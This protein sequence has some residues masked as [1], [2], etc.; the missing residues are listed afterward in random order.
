[1]QQQQTTTTVVSHRTIRSGA[2]FKPD[3][4][5]AMP[6]L[7]YRS[8][9]RESDFSTKIG[10]GDVL[11]F[12]MSVIVYARSDRATQLY[13]YARRVKREETEANSLLA[14]SR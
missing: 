3:I 8:I 2:S 14:P 9:P 6:H 1:M 12:T 10:E 7:R 4:I 11:Y 13:L 5:S